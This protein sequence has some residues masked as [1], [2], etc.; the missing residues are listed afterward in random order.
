[1]RVPGQ[2]AATLFKLLVATVVL[3]QR[4]AVPFG[5]GQLPLVLPLVLVLLAWSLQRGVLVQEPLRLQLCLVALTWCAGMAAVASW[6]GLDWSPLSIIYLVLT[7][8]P[9][10]LRLR[11]ADRGAFEDGLR[12]FLALMTVAAV[13]GI[14]Q[15]GTQLIGWEYRDL[16]SVLPESFVLQGY[17]TSYPVVYGSSIFKAN[18]T[19]FLEPS[20]YSQFLGLAIVVHLHLRRRSVAL[21]LYVVALVAA[22][23]GTGILLVIA[24]TLALAASR[25]D[26]HFLRLMAMLVAGGVAVALSPV[27]SIFASRLEESASGRRSAE[28][29]FSAP[30][31]LT[32]SRLSDDA[33][34]VLSGKGPGAAERLSRQVEEESGLTAVFPV[35]PKLAL[36]YGLPAVAL[37]L[38]FVLTSTLVSAPSLPLSVSVLVMYLTL[39]GSLLQPVTV[40]T[41]FAFTSLFSAK[42]SFEGPPQRVSAQDR[43]A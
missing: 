6:R 14:A 19:W 15:I 1:M 31:E 16:F 2:P 26:K 33:I 20:F 30:Y 10:A 41:L 5:N 8:L 9:F 36:E 23:S 32:A 42:T 3:L 25:L 34:A 24:G 21:Y 12:F 17:N 35:V 13:V 7:Y 27:G 29:R 22:I 39:S 37:F 18:G 11:Q 4:F 28:G 38:W 43:L 40:Y